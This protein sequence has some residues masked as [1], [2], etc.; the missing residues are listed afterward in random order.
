MTGEPP[1]GT[2]LPGVDAVFCRSCRRALNV[3]VVD[4]RVSFLHALE[5]RG[6]TVEH[7]ADPVPLT[8]LSGAVLECDFCSEPGAVWAYVC[9][10]R[11]TQTRIVTARVLDAG[12]YRDRHRAA[13]VRR[14]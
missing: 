6:G 4:G 2:G 10:D 7:R 5:L 1:D 12:D 9:A 11:Y 3:R 8:E 14:T 13:R